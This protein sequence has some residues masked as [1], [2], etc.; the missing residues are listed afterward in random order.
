[1]FLNVAAYKFV[2]LDDLPDRRARLRALGSR[3]GIRGT[4]LLAPEGINLFLSAEPVALREFM[5]EL[6]ADP[7]LSELG[8]RES[9]SREIA[10]GRYLVR[11]KREIITFHRPSLRPVDRRAETVSPVDLRR[12]LDAGRDDDGRP[13]ALVDTRNRFE[14]GVGTFRGAI[15]LGLESFTDLPKA[16]QGRR[17]ELAGHRVVTFCTGGI[18]CEKA[19][20]AMAE[21]GFDNVVQLEGG[22]L[23]WFESQG[24]EH[25]QGELFVFDRRVALTPA[26]AEGN[27]K[28]DYPTRDVSLRE[29]SLREYTSPESGTSQ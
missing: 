7:L 11:L 4:I 10:F 15:D 14:V 8:G 6:R 28:Q 19:A 12:W 29:R 9:W 27:W 13:L 5:A 3:L 18:R 25:W 1:M 20:L 2:D 24:G 23:G 22:V 26:L 16:L 17:N 21:D